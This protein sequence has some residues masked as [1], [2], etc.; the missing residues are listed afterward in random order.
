MI[1]YTMLNRYVII[2]INLIKKNITLT[3]GGNSSEQFAKLK[4]M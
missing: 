1:Y 4:I 2:N 3:S